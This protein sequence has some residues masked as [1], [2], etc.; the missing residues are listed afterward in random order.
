MRY[1]DELSEAFRSQLALAYR[2]KDLLGWGLRQR[3]KQGYGWA[4]FRRDCVAAVTVAAE[5]LPLALALAIACRV[6]PEHGLATAIVA[7]VIAALLGGSRFQVTGPT[8]AFV[9]ILVGI[10]QR[11]GPA[12]IFVAGAMAGVILIGMGLARLGR[13]LQ[14]IPHPVTTGFMTG[15]ALVL[16]LLQLESLLGV[17]LGHVDGLFG[18]LAG[19]WDAR[20][21]VNVGDVAVAVVTLGLLIGAPRVIKRV[22]TSL[23]VLVG[24]AIGV[25]VLARLIPGFHA[26][27]I[28][29][30]YTATLGHEVVRG[31]APLPPLPTVPWREAGFHL[32]YQVIRELLPSALAIAVLGA[33]ESLTSAT[34][35]DAMG[36]EPR[37]GRAESR[38]DGR[39]DGAEHDPNAE[40]IALG[41]ANLVTPFFGGLAAAGTIARTSTNLAAGARS[42]LAAAMSGVV[43]LGVTVA[44]APL[45]A[46]LPLAGLAALLLL[47]ARRLAELRHFAR[48]ARVAP[49][50]DV[51]V[52]LTCFGLTVAF[53]M[54]V[55]VT[56]GVVLAALLFMRRMAVL[57]K[58]DLK[59]P[60]QVGV[61]VPPGVRLYE[62]AG[63]MFFGAAKTAMAAVHIAD[64]DHTVIIVMHHVPTM[65]ATG[66]VALETVL[67]R[68]YRAGRRV[69]FVGM[70]PDLVAL[71][72]RAGIRRAPGKLAYAPDLTTAISM[73]SV[74]ASG[75]RLERPASV[76]GSQPV[77]K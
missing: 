6:S 62:I 70:S 63:P 16:A 57:T 45:V 50:S 22:P 75:D 47:V 48:L 25:A 37:A 64:G 55:A 27:T 30:R 65:D 52:M 61:D 46:Y 69:I 13:F 43:I 15:I 54:V 11:F 14:F 24:V 73:A 21:A 66:L 53:D 40:L 26:V 3:L 36:Q 17:Q 29:D 4:D 2:A 67:D 19:L 49:T 12:G 34:I 60:A 76:S 74:A 32:D 35:A 71:L 10:Y 39:G 72:D 8:A 42:P 68:L 23:L 33:I 59:S 41:I 20:S 28:G 56:V 77:V 9:P 58:V 51:A 5:Q 31:I 18:A 1:V 38:G 44:L 7:A